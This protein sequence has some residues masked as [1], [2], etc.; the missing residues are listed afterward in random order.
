MTHK[1]TT[2]LFYDIE[3]TGLNKCF[4][5]VL[6]FAAIRTDSELNEIARYEITITLNSDVIPSP[7]A[8]ITH[9]I[10]PSEFKTGISEYEAIQKI[11][12]LLNTPNTISVGYNTLGFDDE[13]LRFSFYKNLLP[14]YTHQYANQCGRMDLYP[15][16]VLY[17]LFKPAQLQWPMQND[18]V[19]FK[20]ENLNAAN[21]FFKGQAHNAMVDVEVTLALAKKLHQDKTM[22][23]FVTDYFNKKTDESRL[24]SCE[25]DTEIN[26]QKYKIGLMING[27]LGSGSR[28]VAPVIALGN[29]LHYKNQ[30]LWLRLDQTALL[31][32][33]KNKA[34]A[35]SKV[36]RKRLG[37]PPIFLPLKDR[38]LSL[39]SDD[40]KHILDNTVHWI[41]ENPDVFKAIQTHYQHEK[42]QEV[43]E[44]DIDA[45]LYDSAFPTN[46]EEK[47]YR[48]FHAAI[49]VEKESHI[50][51]FSNDARKIQAM[52]IMG[53]H[54]QNESSDPIKHYFEMELKKVN[55]E[56]PMPMVDFRNEPKLTRIKALAEID[57]IRNEVVLDEQQKKVL[58][59]FQL[60]LMEKSVTRPEDRAT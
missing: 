35:E 26:H 18:T 24:I 46:E 7:Y 54:F 11:H 9:R 1:N 15:I 39:L 38:Y 21:H 45:A 51:H 43:P 47:Q 2:F 13:F 25:T 40:R 6:Q 49:P 56:H 34:I 36:I 5:Q 29:H 32:C 30:T 12:A 23:Q 59:A 53:R 33:E 3:T 17:Y 57:I 22:W 10:G 48:A 50:Q 20:L 8:V 16:T 37:E 27:K 52:R 60:F 41:H 14:P 44:R 19:S 31:S 58:E 4:D 28:Y 42:Y 55:G